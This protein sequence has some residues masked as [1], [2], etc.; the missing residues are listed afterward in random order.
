MRCHC[1]YTLSSTSFAIVVPCPSL[2]CPPNLVISFSNVIFIKHRLISSFISWNFIAFSL[3][4]FKWI[5]FNLLVSLVFSRRN[6][7]SFISLV[8][9]W[10]SAAETTRDRHLTCASVFFFDFDCFRAVTVQEPPRTKNGEVES[11][12]MR[13]STNDNFSL[14]LPR[15]FAFCFFFFAFLLSTV[16]LLRQ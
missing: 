8:G 16:K 2:P 9:S 13:L 1:F 6:L 7:M 5:E 4:N 11:V 3:F 15:A 10:L 12:Q 14:S